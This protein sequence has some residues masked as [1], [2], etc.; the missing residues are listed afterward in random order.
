MVAIERS[1][2]VQAIFGTASNNRAS[3]PGLAPGKVR[4]RQIIA[5]RRFDPMADQA[6]NLAGHG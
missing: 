1:P 5:L 4:T 6:T 3:N 2:F